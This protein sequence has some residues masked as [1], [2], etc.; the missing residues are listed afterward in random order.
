MDF[1]NRKLDAVDRTEEFEALMIERID[2]FVDNVLR[3]IDPVQSAQ[4]IP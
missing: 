1:L 3:V 2:D 4:K